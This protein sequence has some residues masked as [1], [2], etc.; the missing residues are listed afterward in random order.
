MTS[1]DSAVIVSIAVKTA[2]D[3]VARSSSAALISSSSCLGYI[4]AMAVS[5]AATIAE[6]AS[7]NWRKLGSGAEGDD[8]GMKRG[9]D[10]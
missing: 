7:S 8:V 2:R 6:D 5:N 3:V 9:I 4:D 1:N 10:A